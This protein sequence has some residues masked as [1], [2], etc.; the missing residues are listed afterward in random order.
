MTYEAFLF[1]QFLTPYLITLA[2]ENWLILEEFRRV[3][4]AGLG[5]GHDRV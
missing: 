5:D 4:P 3:V 2:G 1:V